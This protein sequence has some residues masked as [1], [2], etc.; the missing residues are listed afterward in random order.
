MKPKKK[1]TKMVWN[2]WEDAEMEDPSESESTGA[3]IEDFGNND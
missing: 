2:N 1:E 3:P